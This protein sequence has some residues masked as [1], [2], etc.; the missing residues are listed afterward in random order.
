VQVAGP[1][2]GGVV[3]LELD[4][5]PRFV[6]PDPRI[7]AVRGC[8]AVQRGPEVLCLESVDLSP[9]LGV[10]DVVVDASVPPWE[11][12]GTVYVRAG[13]G[14]ASG[15][16]WPYTTTDA[17]VPRPR[18]ELYDVPLVAYHDWANRGPATMRV[19]L[20]TL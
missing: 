3:V 2:A 19:W 17:V 6:A 4:T 15:D 16:G 20:P 5:A 1:G 7:D 14:G 12:D 10:D 11:V 13:A 18:P 8:V 9:G